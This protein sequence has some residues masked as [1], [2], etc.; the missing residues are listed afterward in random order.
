MSSRLSR[1]GGSQAGSRRSAKSRRSSAASS[2]RSGASG[3]SGGR[4]ETAKVV[5][6]PK[7]LVRDVLL[8]NSANILLRWQIVLAIKFRRQRVVKCRLRTHRWISSPSKDEHYAAWAR[9]VYDAVFG[10]A[11]DDATSGE[12]SLSH[13]GSEPAPEEPE[14]EPQEAEPQEEAE[15][16]PEPE[17]AEPEPEPADGEAEEDGPEPEPE[18]EPDAEPAAPE[19]APAA[20]AAPAGAVPDS[21]S[22]AVHSVVF[23]H[24]GFYRNGWVKSE[25]SREAMADP[26]GAW[27]PY[28]LPLDNDVGREACPTRT[29]EGRL[30]LKLFVQDALRLAQL[31]R[32][33]YSQP[34]AEGGGER[35]QARRPSALF[36]PWSAEEERNLAA[37]VGAK[38]DAGG[39][40]QPP[41]ILSILCMA[42]E[43]H[44]GR[45]RI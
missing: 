33:L 42:S 31:P 21:R 2:W 14:P 11:G 15:R 17:E 22:R 36:L 32:S 30:F 25:A 35:R 29:W 27:K 13:A 37:L 4:S 45:C 43:L 18:P 39:A 44:L 38:G 24:L 7:G 8:E 41:S 6:F 1:A 34:G 20:D 19:P 16:E 5:M 23:P 28:P 10:P 9:C 40:P 3:T 26:K 12:D